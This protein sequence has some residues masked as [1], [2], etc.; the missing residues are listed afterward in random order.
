MQIR[1]AIAITLLAS[2]PSMFAQDRIVEWKETT[3]LPFEGVYSARAVTYQNHILV[4]ALDGRSYVGDVQSDGTIPA[5]RQSLTV[6]NVN[7]GISPDPW[8]KPC[9]IGDH[10]V[11][12]GSPV[13]LVS[14]LSPSGDILGWNDGPGLAIPSFLVQTAA[15]AGDRIYLVGGWDNG[16]LLDAVQMATLSPAGALSS[17]QSVTPLP[18]ALNDPL[19]MI[20]DGALYVFGGEGE[21]GDTS[22][23]KAVRRAMIREDGS[24][25]AWVSVGSMLTPRPHAMYLTYGDTVHVIGGGVH[26]Y[27]TGSVESAQVSDFGNTALHVESEPMLS[28]ITFS[29]STV[30]GRFGYLVS[31]NFGNYAIPRSNRVFYTVFPDRV[32]PVIAGMPSGCSIW[33]PNGML[34]PVATISGADSETGVVS[35]S[36]QVT[37]NETLSPEDV[38]I[39]GPAAGPKMVELNAKR[40]VN[41]SGRSYLITASAR[42]GAGNLATSQASCTVPH[43]RR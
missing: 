1:S 33:P 19:A 42:D 27:V 16:R 41:G 24:L 37:S 22:V 26:D 5:W 7:P 23:S 43:D 30:V 10:V 31:G 32:P 11:I 25:G 39:T 9:V 40:D 18:V 38:R 4:F 15:C 36:I 6:P 14:R 20:D 3:P 8:P 2:A 28:P 17:W 34:V 21:S 12:P 29:G 13:S 35:L